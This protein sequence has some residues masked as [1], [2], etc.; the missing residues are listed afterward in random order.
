MGNFAYRKRRQQALSGRTGE[1]NDSYASG[2]DNTEHLIIE[3]N[4][5]YEIDTECLK[6]KNRKK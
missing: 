2:Q 4:T 5:I 6:K 3:N 1:K